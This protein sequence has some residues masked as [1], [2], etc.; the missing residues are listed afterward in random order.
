[1]TSLMMV[2]V[3]PELIVLLAGFGLLLRRRRLGSVA[4]LAVGASAMLIVALLADAGWTL[5]EVHL[6]TGDHSGGWRVVLQWNRPVR[7]LAGVLNT[8]GML[9]LVVSIFA[10]RRS[11]SPDAEPARRQP[12]P[13]RVM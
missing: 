10:G 3:L 7:T 11:Q 8:I 4:W 5:Y 9:L 12:E 2:A 1:M 6:L 13:G